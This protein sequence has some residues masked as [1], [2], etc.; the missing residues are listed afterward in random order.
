MIGGALVRFHPDKNPQSGDGFGWKHIRSK[1]PTFLKDV[2]KETAMEGLKG[3]NS[4]VAG[5]K[6]NWKGRLAGVKRGA[7]RAV[8]R[9]AQQE[10][11]KLV[12]KPSQERPFWIMI[13]IYSRRVRRLPGR[14]YK[15]GTFLP[16]RSKLPNYR[17]IQ[18]AHRR[19]RKR[20]RRRRR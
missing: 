6:P 3:L 17:W 13:P 5:G 12:A 8:K 14:V 2:L 4:D 11:K 15:G 16:T 9:K 1:G 19:R 18:S 20:P 7:T 10:I